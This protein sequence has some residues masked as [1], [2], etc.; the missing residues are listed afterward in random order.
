M[1]LS[2]PVALVAVSL[3]AGCS[4]GSLTEHINPYR[5]DIRQGNYVDQ[6]MVA[7]LKRGMTQEQ[8]RFVLGSPLVVDVFHKD[9]WDYVYR[10]RKGTGELEQ[11]AL[12]VFFVDGKLDR[13]EGDVVAGDAV[14]EAEARRSERSRV[15][16]VPAAEQD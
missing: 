9:R 14:A 1:R 16:D 13:I 4:F 5:I 11:R 6:D 10:F 8:V 2:F 3:V 15:V 12:A 7:Q